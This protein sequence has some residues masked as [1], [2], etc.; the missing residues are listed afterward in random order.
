[1]VSTS[2]LICLIVRPYGDATQDIV[3]KMTYSP[4]FVQYITK[5]G[6]TQG[7]S[8]GEF[9]DKTKDTQDRDRVVSQTR[10]RSIARAAVHKTLIPT[11]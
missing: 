2:F 6:V 8:S 3:V 4:Y 11:S 7:G 10:S 9:G 1:M 5:W